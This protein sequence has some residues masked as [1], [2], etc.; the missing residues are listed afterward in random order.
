MQVQT[1]T[2]VDWK[3]NNYRNNRTKNSFLKGC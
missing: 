1:K 2:T 3:I